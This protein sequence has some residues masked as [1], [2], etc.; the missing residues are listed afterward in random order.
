MHK[1]FKEFKESLKDASVEDT[2]DL[3]V[4]RPIAFIIVKLIYH[5]PVTPNQLSIMAIL[6]GI[7]SGFFFA[8]GTP[9]SF[10]YAGLFYALAHIF[11][12]CDGMIARLK[13]NGTF[14]G[15]IIDGF[16]DYTTTTAVFV[17]FNL[18]LYRA[19]FDFLVTPW[20]LVA[21]T[22]FC[23]IV[24]NIIIDYYRSEF[25]AHALNIVNSTQADRERFRAELKELNREKGRYFS[26]LVIWVYL[27]YSQIQ[28][29]KKK[30][31]IAYDPDTYYRAN[32]LLIFLW[33]WLASP[34][35]V[36]VMIISAILFR[37]VIIF[38]YS[39]IAGNI[40]MFVLLIFQIRTNKKIAGK[41][42]G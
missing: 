5:L 19:N 35:Y 7:V 16:A 41:T 17:G 40:W 29:I 34:T 6:T 22:G 23:M 13:K 33:G 18:G 14:I 31:K 38:Y 1:L 20:I 28:L 4:F 26:K 10:L 27:G 36:A 9:S 12:C 39:L 24:H 3:F 11:D 30:E 8:F 15:R 2:M 37:P 21:A 25:M 42:T 32:R